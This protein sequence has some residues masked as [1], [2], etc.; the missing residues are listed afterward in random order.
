LIIATDEGDVGELRRYF[1]I[2]NGFT[3]RQIGR[4]KIRKAVED[5]RPNVIILDWDSF[6][7]D[8]FLVCK[9]IRMLTSSFLIVLASKKDVISEVKVLDHGADYFLAKPI[10]FIELN[11]YVK[12]SL[13]RYKK[14]ITEYSFGDVRVD[15][16]NH[17]IIKGERRFRLTPTEFNLLRYLIE[18]AGE[19]VTREEILKEVWGFKNYILTRTIDQ[20]IARL[21]KK[22]EPNP[23]YPI[24]IRTV[25]GYGYK[26]TPEG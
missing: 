6:G 11:S 9:Q 5:F 23:S 24:Y 15:F 18:H 16:K 22:I 17:E 2:E 8:G 10:S 4:E 21:R 20:Y 26:F 25:H 13:R 3:V 12:A 1:Q 7:E 19:V 14:R